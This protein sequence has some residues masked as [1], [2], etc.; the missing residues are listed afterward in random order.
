[1]NSRK[2]RLFANRNNLLAVFLFLISATLSWSFS[3]TPMTTTI[4]P[5]GADA[6]MTFKVTNESDQ[7]IAVAVRVATRVLSPDGTEKNDP[8]DAKTFL[9]FPARIV[10]KPNSAQNVKVQYRGTPSLT[11]E[12][13]YRVIAEQLPVDFSKSSASGVNILLTDVAALYV[14]PKNVQA[15]LVV[16]SAVGAQKDGVRG[17]TVTVKN[18]GTRHALLSNP[19][20]SVTPS[21]GAAALEFSGDALSA[22]DGQNILAQSERTFFVPWDAA[23][24]GTTYEGAFNAEI[25]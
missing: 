11:G 14:S 18:A 3:F 1:M 8:V 9:V 2:T 19:K 13:A 6:I 17:L 23:V 10:L 12:V 5:S 22:I 21:P 4:G 7:Q 15:K 20:L 16:A 25:E 24:A